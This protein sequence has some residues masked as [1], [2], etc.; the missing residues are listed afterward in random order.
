MSLECSVSVLV[1]LLDSA[2]CDEGNSNDFANLDS[3]SS[4]TGIYICL[5]FLLV[6]MNFY[7]Q[8]KETLTHCE[9]KAYNMDEHQKKEIPSGSI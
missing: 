1:E 3:I 4:W 9:E 6:M 2:E 5:I 8:S 7:F